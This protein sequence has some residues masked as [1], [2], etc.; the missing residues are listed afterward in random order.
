MIISYFTQLDLNKYIY[1]II[2]Y[3]SA[4]C[5]LLKDNQTHTSDN[6]IYRYCNLYKIFN[7][8][9][10]VATNVLVLFI[11]TSLTFYGKSHSPIYV[12]S[13]FCSLFVYAVFRIQLYNCVN[14]LHAF[15]RKIFLI[16][17]CTGKIAYIPIWVVIWSALILILNILIFSHT[18]NTLLISDYLKSFIFNIEISNI[19]LQ[20]AITFILSYVLVFICYMPLNIF[21]IYYVT[22]CYELKE[23]ILS[24]YTMMKCQPRFNYNKLIYVY[25]EIKTVANTANSNVGFLMFF[26]FIFN[27]IMLHSSLTSFIEI[28]G[29]TPNLK[30][31]CIWLI[32][33]SNYLATTVSASYVH[34]ASMFIK[35]KS[36][37]L[38]E[39]NPK[40]ICSYLRF[41]QNCDE[42]IAM[43]VW[44]ILNIKRNFVL[45]TLGTILTYTFLFMS[46]GRQM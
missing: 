39:D 44:G 9:V 10:I 38:Q 33:F 32:S 14:D 42:E 13:L 5:L 46:I 20:F 1:Q 37:R 2:F 41:L 28:K 4:I 19:I 34:E 15:K 11:F 43:S 21:P 31:I 8:I 30:I 18:I 6:K 17:C 26:S 3:L 45:G 23:L 35:E 7:A 24:F 25:N 22:L 16:P 12:I 36:K 27:S 29:V 40:V